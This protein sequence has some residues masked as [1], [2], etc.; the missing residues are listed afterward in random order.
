V[1]Y[2]TRAGSRAPGLVEAEAERYESELL[3]VERLAEA[4]AGASVVYHSAARISILQGPDPEMYRVNVDGTRVVLDAA[5]RA[6]VKRVVYV[7]SIEAFP[8]EQGPYPITEEHGYDPDRNILEYGRSKAQAMRLVQQAAS[9]GMDAVICCPTG[10]VGPPDF[11]PSA[12]GRLI[13]DYLRRKLF[14]YVDGGFDFVDVRDVADG[15]IAASLYGRSGA[16]YLLSGHYIEIPD[17]ID[18]L[19]RASGVKKP[20]LRFPCRTLLPLMPLIETYY[21]LFDRPARFTSG[22]L[23]LLTLGVRV[24]SSLAR[25]ELGYLARPIEETIEDTVRWFCEHSS[26][27]GEVGVRADE[28]GTTGATT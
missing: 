18:W 9:E 21:R 17:L 20:L 14:A 27:A 24:D 25:R 7:G 3:D 8:L 4:F 10:F 26:I 11:R 12:G 23:R 22:S 6:G 15:L 28:T 2:I 5:R 13:A 1:R 19:E 16:V